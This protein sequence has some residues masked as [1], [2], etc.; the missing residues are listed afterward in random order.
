MSR[1]LVWYVV[2]TTTLIGLVFA[3]GAVHRD[4]Y[5]VDLAQILTMLAT[6]G[7][8]AFVAAR[9]AGPV[10]VVALAVAGVESGTAIAVT[11]AMLQGQRGEFAALDALAEFYLAPAM[12]G[13]AALV[14]T[15]VAVIAVRRVPAPVRMRQWWLSLGWAALIFG[16]ICA[17]AVVDNGPGGSRLEVIGIGLGAACL[18]AGLATGASGRWRS[19]PGMLGAAMGAVAAGTA[20]SVAIG[21]AMR[22]VF[23]Q[24]Q[25]GAASVTALGVWGAISLLFAVGACLGGVVSWLTGLPTARSHAI[26]TAAAVLED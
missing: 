11:T 6:I 24:P 3:A 26:G 23:G 16:G 22:G 15:L 1:A 5:A 7:W 13:L 9:P 8:A 12:Y 25:L 19:V 14:L 4:L 21:R 2:V 20:T 10:L 18:A 17:A